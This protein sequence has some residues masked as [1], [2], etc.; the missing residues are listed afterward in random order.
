[1]LDDDAALRCRTN[2]GGVRDREDRMTFRVQFAEDLHDEVLIDLVEVARRLVRKDEHGVVDQGTRNANA[3]LLAARKL[4]RQMV[5]AVGKPHA[6][7]RFERFL[8]V[9]DAVIVLRRHDVF[10]RRQVRDHVKL[11]EDDADLVTAQERQ[12]VVGDFRDVDAVQKHRAARRVIH[13]AD[14]IHER[15]LARAGRPHDGEPIALFHLEVD[16]VER[17]DLAAVGH[18]HVFQFQ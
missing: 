17:L 15:R 9:G 18:R 14:D 12:L 11:L 16:V 13:A 2:L 8:L 3:L 4:A 6:V 1:M 5:G 7:E 10:D